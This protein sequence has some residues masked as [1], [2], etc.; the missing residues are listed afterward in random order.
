MRKKMQISR[1]RR[2]LRW[3]ALLA[4]MVAWA[5][6]PG[7]FRFSSD[8]AIREAERIGGIGQTEVIME[9]PEEGRTLRANDK[10]IMV[11]T[12]YFDP[13]MGWNTQDCAYLDCSKPETFYVGFCTNAAPWRFGRST[14]WMDCYGRIPWE[15][16]DAY[17]LCLYLYEN[18]RWTGTY[19]ID[20]M[21]W[22]SHDGF[23]YFAMGFEKHSWGQDTLLQIKLFGPGN[24]LIEVREFTWDFF[25]GEAHENTP[26]Q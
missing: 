20:D 2:A 14:G 24:K 16:K 8:Q 11:S 7:Q 9:F 5:V 15:L 22:K 3:L 18:G 10:G 6:L 26:A 12:L 4:F 19:P 1:R 21:E 23:Y 13:R 17:H 25:N